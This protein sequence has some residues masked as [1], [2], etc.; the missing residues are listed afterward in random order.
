M[1]TISS[2]QSGNGHVHMS[3][4]ESE[5]PSNPTTDYGVSCHWTPKNIY[6]HFFS[7]AIDPILIKFADEQEMHTIFDEL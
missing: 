7:A 3:L 2:L 6:I 4:D 5:F 1:S